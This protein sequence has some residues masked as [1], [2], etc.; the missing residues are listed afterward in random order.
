M[1]ADLSFADVLLWVNADPR[2]IV[3]VA[4]CRPTT[5]STVLPEDAVGI[6]VSDDEHPYV[7]EAFETGRIVTA[8]P[9]SGDAINM[10]QAVPVRWGDDIVAVLSRDAARVSRRSASALETA[11]LE[12]ADALY[13]M[14]SEGSF[15]TARHVPTRSRAR[16]PVTVSSGSIGK[17]VWSM[18]VRTPCRPITGWDSTRI[19]AG[20]T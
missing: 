7:R 8:Q 18:R 13:R 14:I 6:V 20:R 2:G 10:R 11:Y 16:A 3:C 9:G 4:Q 12:C 17:D 15:P 19:C 5:T 1:L